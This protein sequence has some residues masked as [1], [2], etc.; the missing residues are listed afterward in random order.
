MR[1]R[2]GGVTAIAAGATPGGKVH[3]VVARHGR[4]VALDDGMVGR[5]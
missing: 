3:R 5:A 1:G 2:R 4:V